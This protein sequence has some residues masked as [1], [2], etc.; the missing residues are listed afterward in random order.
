MRSWIVT[1]PGHGVTSGDVVPTLCSTSTRARAAAAG[2]SASSAAIRSGLFA[3]FTGS[4]RTSTL[5]GKRSVGAASIPAN[6][7]NESP[8]RR[9]ARAAARCRA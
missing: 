1:T 9:R 2:S 6:T 5:G 7:T 8:G 4:R 3:A